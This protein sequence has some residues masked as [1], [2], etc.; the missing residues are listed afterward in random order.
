MKCNSIEDTSGNMTIPAMSAGLANRILSI[1][2]SLLDY[3][4]GDLLNK[5]ERDALKDRFRGVQNAIR[6]QKA[7]E[8]K[9]RLKGKK[10][11]SKFIKDKKGWSELKAS[12]NKDSKKKR[13]RNLIG[14]NSYLSPVWCG[15]K[16]ERVID[17]DGNSG[18]KGIYNN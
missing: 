6:R 8:D 10:F 4:M 16:I 18:L 11:V 9:M 15:N 13:T 14:N 2:P 1:T 12:L 17:E 3:L 5:K 7:K